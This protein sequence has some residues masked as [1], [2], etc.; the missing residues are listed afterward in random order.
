MKKKDTLLDRLRAELR[1]VAEPDRAAGMQAYM[2]S[3]MPFHGVSATAMRAAAKQTFAD[4]E[5]ADREAWQRDVL[6]IWRG[7]RFREERYGAIELTGLKAARA[8]HSPDAMPMYEELITGGAWWDYVD[9]IASNRVGD[10]ILRR[11]PAPMRKLM[12]GWSRDAD[13]WKRRTSII[14]QLRFGADTDVGLLYACIKP[15][16]SSKEFFLRKAIGWALRQMARHDPA[17]VQRWVTAHKSELS[18]LSIREA[19]K[20]VDK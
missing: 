9:V 12:L 19:L 17:E 15:S 4:L 13:M 16:M 8:F 11:H 10:L 14:C 6:A 7:A 20:H 5:L 2:K 3:T 18:P 1:R